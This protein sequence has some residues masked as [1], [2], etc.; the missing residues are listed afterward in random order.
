MRATNQIAITSFWYFTD[1]K[2]QTPVVDEA[3]EFVADEKDLE[4]DEALWSL[5]ERWCKH[6]NQERDRD[7]MVRRF[8]EFK[9]L[10]LLVHQE[11]NSD[12]PINWRLTCSLMGSYLR[13]VLVA[14]M[15]FI[16]KRLRS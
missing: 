15:L 1:D 10:V 13:C 4:S 7:E 8:D 3:K 11:N 12:R 16:G 5:Y 14:I 9:R 2:L 6:F